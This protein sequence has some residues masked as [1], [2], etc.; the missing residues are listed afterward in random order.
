MN[1]KKLKIYMA[2]DG[3]PSEGWNACVDRIEFNIGNIKE[4]FN[5]NV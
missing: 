4:E 2:H 3:E 1:S 5:K